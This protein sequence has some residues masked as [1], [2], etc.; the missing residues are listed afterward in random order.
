MMSARDIFNAAMERAE[1][2][3][4]QMH[5]LKEKSRKKKKKD[6]AEIKRLRKAVGAGV[7]ANVE[8]QVKMQQHIDDLLSKLHS[9]QDEGFR[10][11]RKLVS[12]YERISELLEQLRL[13]EFDRDEWMKIAAEFESSQIEINLLFVEIEDEK[14][15]I[16]TEKIERLKE[17]LKR[18]GQLVNQA[19]HSSKKRKKKKQIQ[20]WWIHKPIEA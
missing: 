2:T 7:A 12:A 18:A 9:S 15:E 5:L 19:M 8:I 13:T 16:L 11:R 14:V 1:A 20:K 6:C 3:A 4:V 10:G 17:K